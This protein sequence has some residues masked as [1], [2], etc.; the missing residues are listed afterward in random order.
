MLA[1][2]RVVPTLLWQYEQSLR[3]VTAVDTEA[4]SL[5]KNYSPGRNQ[6]PTGTSASVTASD[7][8]WVASSHV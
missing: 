6:T 5:L 7:E 1:T 3:W 8:E 2:G 4:G